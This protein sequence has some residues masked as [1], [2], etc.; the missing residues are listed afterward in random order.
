MATKRQLSPG[1]TSL[2]K[3]VSKAQ[4]LVSLNQYRQPVGLG[5][6]RFILYFQLIVFLGA[7]LPKVCNYGL[8]CYRRNPNHFETFRHPHIEELIGLDDLDASIALMVQKGADENVIQDQFAIVR[9]SLGYQP[10][11]KKRPSTGNA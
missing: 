3:F 10:A 5:R 8:K 6:A 2:S 11:H 1:L 9:N 4:V 7:S